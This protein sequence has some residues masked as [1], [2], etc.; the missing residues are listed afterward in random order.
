MKPLLVVGSSGHAGVVIE[1]LSLQ[2]EFEIIGLLDSFLPKG[3]KRHGY[4]V[5]GKPEDFSSVAALRAGLSFFIAVGDNWWRNQMSA[6]IAGEI[7]GAV[8]ASITHPRASVAKSAHIGAGTVI[9]A[10]AVV[11]P[12]CRIGAGCII[13]TSCSV[14]HDCQLS[15]FSSVAPGAHVGG[16]VSIGS[17]SSIGIGAAVREEVVIGA[18]TVVGAGAVVLRDLPDRVVAY[19]VPARVR[20]YRSP[21]EKYLSSRSDRA[22]TGQHARGALL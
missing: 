15:E 2:G 17:R 4:C 1:A 8:F 11:A 16:T 21:D 6:R 18:D 7:D 9:M 22:V 12:N 14:D 19:G 13:N 20:R 10:G 3:T 5:I